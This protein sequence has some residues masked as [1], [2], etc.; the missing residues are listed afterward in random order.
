[1]VGRGD[2]RYLLDH[3]RIRPVVRAATKDKDICCSNGAHPRNSQSGWLGR[4]EVLRLEGDAPR[5]N[6]L[7]IGSLPYLY[8]GS[9]RISA[10]VW[11]AGTTGNHLQKVQCPLPGGDPVP[12]SAG[13]GTLSRQRPTSSLPLPRHQRPQRS[14]G[15]PSTGKLG[16]DKRVSVIP[17]PPRGTRTHLAICFLLSP[18]PARQS[19]HARSP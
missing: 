17:E 7:R 3:L 19:S 1:M 11:A 16:R 14:P 15:A 18:N 12:R 5:S 4:E 8:G 2:E 10:H 13:A 6:Q 9:E